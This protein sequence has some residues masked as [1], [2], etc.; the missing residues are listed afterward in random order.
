MSPREAKKGKNAQV[1]LVSHQRNE[2]Q[3]RI[4]DKGGLNLGTHL[5]A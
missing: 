1:S 4:G 5:G 2:V 3:V